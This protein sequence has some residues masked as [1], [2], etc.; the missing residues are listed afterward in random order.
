MMKNNWKLITWILYTV[1]V[2]GVTLFLCWQCSEPSEGT[3]TIKEVV[4]Y[5]TAWKEV[6]VNSIQLVPVK[7]TVYLDTTTFDTAA[8]L[9]N[10]FTEKEYQFNYS[11]SNYIFKQKLTLFKNELTF[12]K[13]EIGAISKNII[14]EVTKTVSPKYQLFVGGYIFVPF[15]GNFD[16]AL[17]GSLVYKKNEIG[18]GYQFVNRGITIHY[19]YNIFR[20]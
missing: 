4:T 10:Y 14:R 2:V 3:V 19:S 17:S 8:V 6:V 20:K 11:D 18:I 5:D 7:E 15:S 13:F 1:I 9:K 12:N 16:I